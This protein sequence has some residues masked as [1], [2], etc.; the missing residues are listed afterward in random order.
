[1]C[2][3]ILVANRLA[4]AD[5]GLVVGVLKDHDLGQVNPKTVSR[6]C[7]SGM[8]SVLGRY[9][10]EDRMAESFLFVRARGER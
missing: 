8:R 2:H 9:A 7:V 3:T 4:D 10:C 6:H 1:V 5:A